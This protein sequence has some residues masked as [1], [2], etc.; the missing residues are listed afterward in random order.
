MINDLLLKKYSQLI[1]QIGI[2]LQKGQTVFLKATPENKDLV[3]LIT[4]EAYLLGAKKVNIIWKDYYLNYYHLKYVDFANLQ[5]NQLLINH[6]QQLVNEQAVY[7]SLISPIFELNKDISAEKLKNFTAYQK[8][9]LLFFD[10]YIKGIKN[11]W[12]TMA[13]PNEKWAKKVFP[14]LS[15]VAA[16]KKLWEVVFQACYVN[17]KDN[18]LVKWQTHN[19]KLLHYCRLMNNLNFQTLHFKNNLGTNLKIKLIK[20]HVWCGGQ[21]T[22]LENQIA[23]NPNIPMEEIL[24]MPDKNVC[25]GFL[26]ATKP[27]NFQNKIIENVK[28]EFKNGRVINFYAHKEQKLLAEILKIDE[29]ASYLGEIALVSHQSYLSQLNIL[30]FETLLDENSSCHLALGQ[31]YPATLQQGVFLNSEELL[32]K[33]GNVS[34]LHMDICFGSADLEIIGE[35]HNNKIII[36]QNGDFV[37]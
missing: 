32:Q 4:K 7:I 5:N 28:L 16:L 9:K 31:S 24:T 11:Q 21:V 25:D 26:V 29:G 12:T 19:Q 15:N 33:G 22:A 3:R 30:F 23:F 8:K 13:A 34:A 36:F 17:K 2:N 10:H 14:H 18:V 35:T 6:Y 37:M 20:N 1:L 27:I